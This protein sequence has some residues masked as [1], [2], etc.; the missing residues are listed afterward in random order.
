MTEHALKSWSSAAAVPAARSVVPVSQEHVVRALA[1]WLGAAFGLR[2]SHE[3]PEQRNKYRDI[4]LLPHTDSICRSPEDTASTELHL[5]EVRGM[6]AQ[7]LRSERKGYGNDV[8]FGGTCTGG[9]RIAEEHISWTLGQGN[10]AAPTSHRWQQGHI[11]EG[12]R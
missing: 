4:V 9:S 12:S 8:S 5:Q 10:A 6:G 7:G 2:S 1:A 3:S 11:S